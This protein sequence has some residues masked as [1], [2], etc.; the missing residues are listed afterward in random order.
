MKWRDKREVYF[1]STVHNSNNVE[2]KKRNVIKK[3]PEVVVDYNN[4]M[5]GVDMSD[6]VIIAYSTTR[7][8]LKKFVSNT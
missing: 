7:K 6:G 1:V 8:R 2:V 5:G 3:I 4:K